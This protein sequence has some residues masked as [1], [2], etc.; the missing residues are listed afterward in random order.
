[1]A[2]FTVKL[3]AK[4]DVFAEVQV[5]AEDEEQAIA[6]ALDSQLAASQDWSHYPGSFIPGTQTNES[7]SC[8]PGDPIDDN[9][10]PE[11]PVERNF[12]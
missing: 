3:S 11:E 7:I 4:A 10:G 12:I 9:G 2:K 1:M 8:E 5:D 6:K